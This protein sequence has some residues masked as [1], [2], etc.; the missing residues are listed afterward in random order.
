M[1]KLSIKNI[2][3]L[4]EINIE[5]NRVNVLIG[6][7]SSG[8]STVAKLISFFNWLEKDCVL[9]QDIDRINRQFL[10]EKFIS[11]Y[12]LQGYFSSLSEIYY[13]GDTLIVKLR[14]LVEFSAGSIKVQKADKFS[15]VELSKNAYIP[16]ERNMLAL[17]GIFS[18]KMP[19]NYLL[20][21][22]D[23]WQEIR[24]KYSGDT[25]LSLLNLGD[26]YFFNEK[27][28]VDKIILKD[29]KDISFS[30][31]SSGLQS[32]TPLCVC[33]DY[34]T[35]WIYANEENRS[36]EER[37]RYRDMI[38]SIVTTDYQKLIADN[39]GEDV[40]KKLTEN[41]TPD[42]VKTLNGNFEESLI[43]Y[44]KIHG[45]LDLPLEYLYLFFLT[46]PK[47]RL[48]YRFTYPSATNLVVE[49]PEQNL[50]PETQ[51]RLVYYILSKLE[52]RIERDSLVLTTH[53]PYILYALNNC[54]MA[55]LADDENR[56]LVEQMTNVPKEAWINPKIVSVWE[57]DNGKIRENKTIQDNRGLIRGNYFDR[58]MRNVM[59]DF[60][61]IANFI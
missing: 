11:Y 35:Q 43:D 31:A 48:Q 55:A 21:F 54:M 60:N 34:L 23:D 32:V 33:I 61:N 9:H 2:G 8:K 4:K 51:V 42:T 24:Q 46:D 29:G 28:N 47:N 57:L 17:P 44:V 22:I 50:F 58:I 18:I 40:A 26:T 16:S 36:A 20:E 19:P 1:A 37:K 14:D 3:P 45:K 49:E 12:N 13:E 7:Q 27:E 59:A 56:E 41:L 10:E 52:H 5:L 53:S 15:K 38:H 25:Q 30:Q 39:F 6:P